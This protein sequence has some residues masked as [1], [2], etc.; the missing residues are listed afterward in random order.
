MCSLK[1]TSSPRISSVF[2]LVH[3]PDDGQT[4]PTNSL[5][6]FI[7]FSDIKHCNK[8]HTSNYKT[9]LNP[10]HLL[11]DTHK[12][13]WPKVF[14]CFCTSLQCPMLGAIPLSADT[15]IVNALPH[16]KTL[17]T[18]TVQVLLSQPKPSSLL[19][20]TSSPKPLR[21][22]PSDCLPKAFLIT[23]VP[24]ISPFLNPPNHARKDYSDERQTP[25]IFFPKMQPNRAFR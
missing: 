23:H 25:Q 20:S 13:L 18:L 10:N 8:S 9:Y 1:I 11:S 4:F 12:F 3:C 22:H 14:L 17:V 6:K 7:K 19:L 16:Y 21:E 15:P 2:S 5:P 24:K